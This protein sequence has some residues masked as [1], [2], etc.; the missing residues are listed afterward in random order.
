MSLTYQ[1]PID[2]L[3]ECLR[4]VTPNVQLKCIACNTVVDIIHDEITLSAPVTIPGYVSLATIS[5]PL[6]TRF[7]ISNIKMNLQSEI[8]SYPKNEIIGR[9]LSDLYFL[10]DRLKSLFHTESS[11][12][13]KDITI[14]FARCLMN[15]DQ[16]LVRV[17][18]LD[19]FKTII[20]DDWT[21]KNVFFINIEILN[22]DGKVVNC[23]SFDVEC[24]ESNSCNKILLLTTIVKT[25]MP[26]DIKA[27]LISAL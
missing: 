10:I 22:Q 23:I 3:K 16:H 12:S 21:C 7:N 4:L 18:L 5:S 11:I 17:R 1:V 8:S 13:L 25:P 27:K 14:R 24:D 15:G 19:T 9:S 20:K 6:K 26:D 2:I